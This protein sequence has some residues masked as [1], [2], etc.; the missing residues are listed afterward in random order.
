MDNRK[1]RLNLVENGIFPLKGIHNSDSTGYGET[2]TFQGEGKLLGTP[3]LF[4]RTSGCNLRCYVLKNQ[5][6]KGPDV[7]MGDGTLKPITEIEVGEMVTFKSYDKYNGTPDYQQTK[8]QAIRYDDDVTEYVKLQV[9]NFGEILVTPEHPFRATID[10]KKPS[11]WIEAR[12]LTEHH[13]IIG[14]S[15]L[16]LAVESAEI[17]QVDEP[18]RTVN[19]QVERG[20]Y[21]IGSGDNYLSTHNCSWIGADGN[22]SPCDTPYSSHNPERNMQKVESIL[23]T[24]EANIQGTGIRYIVV[25]GG[26]PTLQDKPLAALLE[27]LQELG[28]H[29]TIETNGTIFHQEIAKHTDLVSM[30]PKLS[31]STP[32]E[33]NLKNTGIDYNEKWA[34]R[35]ERDRINI[36]SIQSYIDFAR[37]N[38]NDFQLKFVVSRPE[39]FE[40]IESDF[41]SKLENWNVDDVCIMPEGVTAD[42]LAERTEWA[43]KM[44]LERGYRF[45]PRLHILMYGKNRYV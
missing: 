3:C 36:E 28:L 10:P 33:A 43:A 24:V 2:G 44:A 25:S 27:G 45:T 8:V 20:H 1:R 12:S 29:T 35:H 9:E 32:W 19:I 15:R 38:G 42:D 18:V 21:L 13:Y 26:E 22:G 4:I 37:S 39:D 31:T 7:V 34:E 11:I 30:S 16:G 5:D 40:E 23:A 17:I 6:D 14:N 41:L